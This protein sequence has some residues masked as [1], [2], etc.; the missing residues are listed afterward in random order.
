[1]T[2]NTNQ[3]AFP[4]NQTNQNQDHH[5]MKLRDYFAAHAPTKPCANFLEMYQEKHEEAIEKLQTS[6]SSY[7]D[8]VA[9]NIKY[10][11]MWRYTYAD[12]MIAARKET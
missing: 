3:H 12:A 11:T 7:A 8:H 4:S 6:D 5:G 10:V 9:I 2:E 1:M